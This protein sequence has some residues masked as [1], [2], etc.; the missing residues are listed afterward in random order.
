MNLFNV[1]NCLFVNNLLILSI[2]CFYWQR[3]HFFLNSTYKCKLTRA[4]TG[5]LPITGKEKSIS[6][7]EKKNGSVSKKRMKVKKRK[8]FSGKL[9]F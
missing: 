1:I 5:F 8:F 9:F 2:S 4:G 7:F 3:Y 6:I